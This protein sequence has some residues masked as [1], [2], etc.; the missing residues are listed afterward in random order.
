MSVYG[1]FVQI[2]FP[3]VDNCNCTAHS[4]NHRSR[5]TNIV[6]AVYCTLPLLREYCRFITDVGLPWTS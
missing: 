1:R 4:I 3:V 6:A 2:A 5:I